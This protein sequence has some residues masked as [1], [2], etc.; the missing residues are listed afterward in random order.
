MELALT[1][2]LSGCWEVPTIEA[3]VSAQRKESGVVISV[4][5]APACSRPLRPPQ[6]S[7]ITIWVD[8]KQA[9]TARVIGEVELT[10]IEIENP[11][12]EI[13]NSA[14]YDSSLLKPGVK[15]E[16]AISGLYAHGMFVVP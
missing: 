2:L 9:W 11:P 6:D 10:T 15:A 12:E 7:W 1:F 13:K 5:E 14:G 16:F 3:C 4:T 8:G